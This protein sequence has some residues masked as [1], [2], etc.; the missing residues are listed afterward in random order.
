MFDALF[1][2]VADEALLGVIEQAAREEAEASARRLAAIAELTYRT[3]D[4][5]DERSRRAFDLWAGTATQVGAALNVGHRRASAQMCIAMA[6]R[7]RLPRVA[8]LFC[9]G[10]ISARVISELTWRTHLVDDARVIAQID[11]D[12]ADK[13]VSWGPLSEHKLTGAIDA[14]IDRYDPDAVRRAED[15]LRD[16]DFRVGAHEDGAETTTVWGRLMAADGVVL[17]RRIATMINQVC[18]NDPRTI[19]QR[20]SDAAGALINGNQYLPCRCGSPDCPAA[21]TAAPASNIV[22]HVIAEQAALDAA[23]TDIAETLTTPAETAETS[24]EEPAAEVRESAAEVSD[25]TGAECADSL[26]RE[27]VPA[28]KDTGLALLPGSTVMP[29]P[30]LAE[31]I[32]A[33]AKIK[34]LWVP[35]DDPEPHYRPSARLA[36]FV[37]ARDMFCRFPGCDVPADRC[38]VDHSVPWPY[39]LTHPSNLNCKCRTHHLGK[40]FPNGAEVWAERQFPDATITWTAPDGRSYT[41]RPGSRLFFPSWNTA[42]AGLPPPPPIP[43][44]DPAR[45]AKIPQ[46]RRLRSAEN[47]ARIKAE[48]AE[49]HSARARNEGTAAKPP[50]GILPGTIGGPDDALDDEPPF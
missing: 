32:R 40:T 20:R 1:A 6:L 16:R 43:P 27:P 14:V 7:D 13:A 35:G 21:D 36:Q 39:G 9:Q 29:I 12:L 48:R 49:N 23:H 8:A 15:R 18:D 42:T 30:A 26:D 24:A 33:G 45:S 41:T 3:V 28:L 38:D 17:E 47:A 5:D 46:R 2:D 44:P 25:S 19:G 10:R 22:I 34:P 50:A 31:A 37:R 4:D 11:A